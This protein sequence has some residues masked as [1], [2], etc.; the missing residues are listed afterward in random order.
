M[1]FQRKQR[2]IIWEWKGVL[3]IYSEKCK[4]TTNFYRKIPEEVKET[5]ENIENIVE[6]DTL[7]SVLNNLEDVFVQF[8]KLL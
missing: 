6:A 4:T 3:K 8:C 5:V 7:E 1:V 2:K